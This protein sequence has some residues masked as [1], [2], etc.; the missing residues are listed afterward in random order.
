[1]DI[2]PSF[3]VFVIL[4]NIPVHPLL[5]SILPNELPKTLI[6]LS[7]LLL[8]GVGLAC[9]DEDGDAGDTSRTSRRRRTD[10]DSVLLEEV[11]VS[12]RLRRRRSG[13]WD[14]AGLVLGEMCVDVDV[15]LR[16]LGSSG[17]SE[18]VAAGLGVRVRWCCFVMFASSASILTLLISLSTFAISS[19]SPIGTLFNSSFNPLGDDRLRTG[20]SFLLA[21][22]A[23]SNLSTSFLFASVLANLTTSS[24][25][26][27]V[28][29]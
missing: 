27:N 5:L 6:S 8:L 11:S 23:S 16:R 7:L 10:L 24:T 22:Y 26:R 19:S 12:L 4:C 3:M 21:L 20:A 9:R 13:V 1:M 14:F 17:R 29:T 15:V 2:T 28:R 25:S 18:T